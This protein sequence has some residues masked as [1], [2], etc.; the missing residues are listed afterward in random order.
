MEKNTVPV[1]KT[2]EDALKELE[3]IVE[4]FEN[5][6]WT[7]EESVEAYKRGVLLKDFCASK[8][9]EAK[10]VLETVAKTSSKTM[11]PENGESVLS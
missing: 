1:A 2:F 8:L 5:N 9:E 4:K 11:G 7:L 10:L 6:A 3:D